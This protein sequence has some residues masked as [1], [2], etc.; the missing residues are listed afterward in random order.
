MIDI[1]L[2]DELAKTGELKLTPEERSSLRM[3][4][5]EVFSVI[6]QLEA[7]PLDETIRPVIHGNPYPAEIRC[8]LREDERMP[9]ENFPEII[10]QA[11][12]TRDGCIISP[13]IVHEKLNTKKVA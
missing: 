7:I 9:F 8:P 5:N 10:M 12:L 11:P 2:F 6:R 13:D 4:L 3:E 1:A